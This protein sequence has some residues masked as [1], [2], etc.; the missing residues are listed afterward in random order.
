MKLVYI[1]S[2]YTK[3]DVAQN[4][5]RQFE[6]ADYLVKINFLPYPPLFSHFWHFLFP[7]PH[8]FW[9]MIDLEMI[10]RCDIL[11]RLSGESSGADREVEFAKSIGIPVVYSIKE[12]NESRWR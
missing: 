8:E 7:H 9:M 2:P 3:G 6:V 4:V 11:L 5:R 12:L 10:R 1:A